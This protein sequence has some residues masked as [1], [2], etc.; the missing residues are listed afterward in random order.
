M[1]EIERQRALRGKFLH[2]LYEASGGSTHGGIQMMEIGDQLGLDR[3]ETDRVVQWLVDRDIHN[4]P[5]LAINKWKRTFLPSKS[6]LPGH[7]FSTE[8]PRVKGT[9]A[10]R[11]PPTASPGRPAEAREEAGMDTNLLLVTLILICVAYHHGHATLVITPRVAAS[12]TSAD[13]EICPELNSALS[14]RARGGH[15]A[16][17]N[18]AR[19][20]QIGPPGR[21]PFTASG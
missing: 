7:Y 21:R 6:V 2:L 17:G 19:F 8:N 13:G 5:K 3:D 1:S 20:R 9:E 11:L 16:I 4:W 15:F 10:S 14:R 18:S 12:S